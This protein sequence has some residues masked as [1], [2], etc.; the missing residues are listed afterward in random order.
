M[1]AIE[2]F[3]ERWDG[4]DGTE[5]ANRQSF[6][7]EL[8]DALDLPRPDPAS[9]DTESNTYVFE[10]KVVRRHPD[11]RETYGFIDLYRK[12][13]FVLEAKQSNQALGT[14][15]W[16]DAMLR[17]HG[18]AQR[19]ARDLPPEEGRPPF[20]IVTDVG[21][22]IELYSEFSQSGATYVPF[23]DPRSHRI[24]LERLREPEVQETLRAVWLDPLSLD[25]SRRSA[26][27]TR[28]I[29]TK[30]AK[31]AEQLE[32]AGYDPESVAA[33]LMRCLFTMFAE[34]VGL[35]PKSCFKELLEESRRD[36]ALFSRLVPGLWR[37]MNSGGFSA[38]I[39]GD[40]LRF[41]GG[42]FAEQRVLPLEKPQIDLLL[43]AAA[44]DWKDVEPA[45]FGT[46]LERALDP[47]ERHKLGAH[48][49]PRA[50]VERLVL[51]TIVEPLRDEWTDVQAAAAMLDRSG[52]R[53]DAVA[54]IDE[55][56]RRLCKIRVLDPACGSG[57]FLYVTL[58]HL[59]RLEG[60]IFN[61][62]E[63]LGETQFRLEETGVTVDPHQMLGIESNPRAA[64][65]AEAV[66]WI[67]YLQWHFRT[68]GDVDPP[69]PVL[70]DFHNIENRDAVLEWDKVEYVLGDDGKPATRWDGRTKKKH[71]VTGEDV[72]DENAR[73]PLERYVNPR[74]AVWPEAEFV[75]GNPPFIGAASMR[76]ALGDGYVEA[77]RSTY[78]ELPSSTDYVM[79][80]WHNAAE[81]TRAGKVR[82]FGLIT[83]NSIRQTF[84][85]RVV[86]AHLEAKKPLSLVFAI[87]DH[88]WVDSADGA[89]VR[90]AMTV[91]SAE[92]DSGTLQTVISETEGDSDSVAT[93]LSTRAG[94]LSPAL[95]VGPNISGAIGLAGNGG[96]SSRGVQLIGSGFIVSE[97]Q[98][99][100]IGF[101]RTPELHRHV[102]L[103]R[104]GKD[105]TQAPR[106]VMVLDFFGLAE[107]EVRTRFPEAYQWILER[108]R[109]ERDAKSHSPD[110]AAY[111]KRWWLFGKPR[112]ELRRYLAGLK[113]Y[114]ATVETS[115]HRFFT[116]LDESI[117]PDNMLVNI[118]VDD[119]YHLGV[120]SS[121]THVAW[122]L[123][124]GG[125][126][127]D[128][129]RYNKTRCFETFPFPDPTDAQK[130][131]IR[132]LAEQ[133]DAHRKSRQELH[134]KLTMTG[135]YNVL[136]KLR[137]GEELSEKERAVH[138][139]G[140]VSVLAQLHDELDA[141]VLDAYGWSD[142]APVL[143]GKPG[144]TT[145]C[146]TKS[147]EQ[148]EA[149]ET[150]LQRL[151]DLNAV[152]AAEE[153]KGLVRWLRPEF[154][155]PGGATA[156]QQDKLIDDALPEVPAAA[157]RAWPKSLPEQIRALRDALAEQPGPA[158]PEQLARTF[159]RAKSARVSE[160]L[161]T[162]AA[163]GQARRTDAGYVG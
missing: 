55:F 7:N 103:Y 101:G 9:K 122:A 37:A 34:D 52:K 113:R 87:P 157:K 158:A 111:A 160:L 152:R 10:R 62:L 91:G 131:R 22:S 74:K 96:I 60:E 25:P 59:K 75:V 105:L 148:E 120:L 89:A 63:D 81:L 84:N 121:R 108:V 88:P 116:F 73:V 119:A 1:P 129:P 53:K 143:V 44:A 36:P 26:R 138:S 156:A 147:P 70:R 128:R 109:P 123:A 49:T 93:A 130:A 68:R 94:R 21:R 115:K 132:D 8:C 3:I 19:Y 124:M 32:K 39:R 127:E 125:T 161:E 24:R 61:A 11:G 90:I 50:Y 33:F 38:E 28:E 144:G 86:Q 20:L 18:Q 64:R 97:E 14:D 45:I 31:L 23:P 134:P 58:E 5:E 42:L 56:H 99:R 2:E 13:S 66:L 107:G 150:L 163:L 15:A 154:Q 41:N 40:V 65:I 95:R 27:V 76:Q 100:E 141:A 155:N 46:L 77:L 162:L 67:G 80:W 110:G 12:G 6:L 137:L 79:Y 139:R 146:R 78:S 140:L 102:Q 133:L 104:N 54:E 118:A 4:A 47:H 126:L 57:N 16:A 117:L 112:P 149:E 114:V 135:M 51:P 159:K 85:R 69:E 72:P 83:T 48:Y 92:G 82:R 43:E 153:T 30:L 106:G 29:A 136:E 142:L 17:A 71:P 98:A 151:V 145:P 35:L